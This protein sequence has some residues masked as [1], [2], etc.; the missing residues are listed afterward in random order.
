MV[1]S[2]RVAGTN[3]NEQSVA[4]V[5]ATDAWVLICRFKFKYPY[6]ECKGS[7]G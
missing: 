5:N 7:T 3:T 4:Q 1:L 2:V 6:Q